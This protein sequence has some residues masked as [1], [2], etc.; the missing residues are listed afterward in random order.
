MFLGAGGAVRA[1]AFA[2]AETSAPA[3]ITLLGRN[4][5]RVAPLI[6]D[7]SREANVP[8]VQGDLKDDLSKALAEHDVVIQGTPIGMFG[9]QEGESIVPADALRPEQVIFDMVYRPLKT[10]L[11]QDAEATGCPIIPGLEMLLNQAELQFERWT[12]VP[13]PS[14]VMRD[15]LLAALAE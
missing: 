13:A 9:H 3:Q 5:E 10:R 15:A 6:E 11:I 14:Q 8:I 2:F 12:G 4:S 7:L 1:V